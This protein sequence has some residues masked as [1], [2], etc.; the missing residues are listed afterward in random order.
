LKTTFYL[1]LQIKQTSFYFTYRDK[2]C[3]PQSH[4]RSDTSS[5]KNSHAAKM[6]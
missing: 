6:R 1:L 2:Y 4:A 3:C 5:K